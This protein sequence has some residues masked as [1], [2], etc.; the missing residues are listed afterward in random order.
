MKTILKYV[1]AVLLSPFYIS[2]KWIDMGKA[3]RD[4]ISKSS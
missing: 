2:T 3:K 1:L 4:N